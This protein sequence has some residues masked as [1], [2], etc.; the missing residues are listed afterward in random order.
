VAVGAFLAGRVRFTDIHRVVAGTVDG[1]AGR[2]SGDD[3][4][5]SGLEPLLAL[6]TQAR[7]HAEAIVAGLVR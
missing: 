3:S 4:P 1:V 2:L 6:D 7:V 5:T